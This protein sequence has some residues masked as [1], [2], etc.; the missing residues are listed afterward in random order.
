MSVNSPFVEMIGWSLVVAHRSFVVVHSDAHVLQLSKR[1]YEVRKT[2][3]LIGKKE[4]G[5]KFSASD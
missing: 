2:E 3:Y 5:Q 1:Q 4:V